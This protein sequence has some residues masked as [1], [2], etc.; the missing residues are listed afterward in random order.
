MSDSATADKGRA[1]QDRIENGRT[2]DGAPA[3][4]QGEGMGRLAERVLDA[5]DARFSGQQIPAAAQAAPMAADAATDSTTESALVAEELQM[6]K[7]NLPDPRVEAGGDLLESI[8]SIPEKMAFK[9][10]EAAEMVGVKQYVLRY[11]ESEFEM[12]RPRKSKN[13]QRVYSRRDIETALMIKKL[14]YTDRFSIEGA[15]AALRQLK[16]QVKEEKGIKA[17]AQSQE[18]AVSKL[19]NLVNEIR[20]IREIFG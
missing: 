11:W 20:R 15:R 3:P 7:A 13:N 18:T 14:L 5:A 9:I 6:L 10:G 19:K 12:L 4:A 17:M 2:E 16:S 8:D 1:D